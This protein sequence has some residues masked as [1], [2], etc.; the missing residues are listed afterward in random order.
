MT[1]N[2]FQDE[3]RASA[4]MWVDLLLAELHWKSERE[5]VTT[6][7]QLYL[8]AGLPLEKVLDALKI[9]AEEWDERVHETRAA[10]AERVRDIEARE[11]IARAEAAE[12]TL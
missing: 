2:E 12:M 7:A 11:R 8:R 4:E 6:R 3:Y 1:A 9:T 10:R 5:R